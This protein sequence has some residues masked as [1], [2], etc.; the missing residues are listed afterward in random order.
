MAEFGIHL[1]AHQPLFRWT[2]TGAHAA[3]TREV[4]KGHLFA[5]HMLGQM[6][7]VIQNAKMTIIISCVV[8]VFLITSLIVEISQ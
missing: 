2:E 4:T 5:L 7:N 3:H 6:Y 1:D 8:N